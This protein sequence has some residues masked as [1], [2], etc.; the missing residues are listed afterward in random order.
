MEVGWRGRYGLSFSPVV[1]QANSKPVVAAHKLLRH[2]PNTSRDGGAEFYTG[3]LDFC[4]GISCDKGDLSGE[5]L[6][7]SLADREG[8][9]S[10]TMPLWGSSRDTDSLAY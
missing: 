1:I 5:A 3:G 8:G 9:S 7:R 4:Y 6:D 2:K 10:R